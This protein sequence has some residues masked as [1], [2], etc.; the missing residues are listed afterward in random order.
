MTDTEKR[1]RHSI[2]PLASFS[3]FAIMTESPSHGRPYTFGLM[4]PPWVAKCDDA[5]SS[6]SAISV[7]AC[8]MKSFSSMT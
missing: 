8:D 7:R 6:P 5:D 4:A 3:L 2:L 1:T